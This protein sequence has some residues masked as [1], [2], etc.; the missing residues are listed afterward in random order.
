[1]RIRRTLTLA[2][3]VLTIVVVTS[4]VVGQTLGYPILLGYVETGSMSPTMEPGDGFVAVPHQ[5]A[6]PVEEGDVVVFEAER[7]HGGGLTTHRVVDA[8]DRGYVTKGD[9][10]PFPDQD[11]KEPPVKRAQV[12]AKA[13]QVNGHVVV[14]PRLGA[15]VETV[16]NALVTVQRRMARLFGVESLLGAQ[17]V[18]YLL[19]GASVVAYAVE[20]LREEGRDDRRRDR[21]RTDGYD[22]RLVLGVLALVL[23]ATAT[24]S[25]VIP[26][27]TQ[28]FGVVSAESDAPGPRIIETGTAE[29]LTYRVP[30]GGLVPVVVFLDPASEGVDV[31]PRETQVG[32]RTTVNATVTLSAPPETG[33]YRRFLVER[34]YLAVLPR[35]TIGALY[36]VHPWAPI[37]AIDLLLGG[38]FYL[39]GRAVVGT[40]RIRVRS[41]D[42]PTS[43]LARLR[44]SLR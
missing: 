37:V 8:T 5:I 4:L 26:A 44:R 15:G 1:M 23:V 28:K 6:G 27:G 17:G 19:L 35:S 40:G 14:I 16:Q 24:A 43:T 22:A 11:G 18:A 2:L 25:M 41:R 32:S 13:L 9:A 30:N 34:R 21:S 29:N 42:R 33:Y 10:N 38:G 31:A 3:E 12:V 7:L 36:R 20:T 39:V